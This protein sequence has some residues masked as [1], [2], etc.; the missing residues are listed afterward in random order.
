MNCKEKLKIL[1]D[2]CEQALMY[3]WED[4]FNWREDKPSA[5]WDEKEAWTIIKEA[6]VKVEG[7]K[8]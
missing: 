6:F 2:A 8:K 3:G 5:F 1:M 4:N 7:D